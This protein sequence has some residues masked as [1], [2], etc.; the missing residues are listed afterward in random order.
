MFPTLIMGTVWVETPASLFAAHPA[1]NT[2]HA[3]LASNFLPLMTVALRM[4]EFLSS[5]FAPAVAPSKSCAQL[6]S[7]S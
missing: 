7:P 2:A 4:A 1:R 3:A 6:A 5:S